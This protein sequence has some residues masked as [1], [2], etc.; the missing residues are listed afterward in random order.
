MASVTENAD[1]I[2]EVHNAVFGET[3]F[4]VDAPDG[5]HDLEDVV[6]SYSK[7]D[8]SNHFSDNPH[9]SSKLVTPFNIVFEI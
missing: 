8:Y 6:S 2:T 3:L 1:E 7:I 9:L 5:E 4:A